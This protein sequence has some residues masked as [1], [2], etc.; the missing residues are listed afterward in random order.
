[1]CNFKGF[2]CKSFNVVK[3]HTINGTFEK[4]DNSILII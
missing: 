1:M 3:G 2:T 4:A